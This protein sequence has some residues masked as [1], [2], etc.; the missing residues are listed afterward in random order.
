MNSALVSACGI[1]TVY[2]GFLQRYKLQV[3]I[4]WMHQDKMIVSQARHVWS[5]SNA[6]MFYKDNAE[7]LNTAKHG[8]EFI[9]DVMWD[10]E[11]GVLRF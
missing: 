3:G 7:L 2:A 6:A 5:L 1:D 9:K 10:K 4:G 8:F 11:F